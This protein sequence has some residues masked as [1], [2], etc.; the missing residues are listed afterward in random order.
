VQ[1]RDAYEE[2][3]VWDA[4]RDLQDHYTIMAREGK[5]INPNKGHKEETKV[6]GR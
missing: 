4:K 2:E 6:G 5:D 1:H 3:E